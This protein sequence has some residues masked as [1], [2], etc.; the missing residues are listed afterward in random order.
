M[1]CVRSHSKRLLQSRANTHR[2]NRTTSLTATAFLSILGAS[3]RALLWS[4]TAGFPSGITPRSLEPSPKSDNHPTWVCI[5][6]RN[7]LT[8]TTD[9]IGLSY[10]QLLSGCHSS[11]SLGTDWVSVSFRDQSAWY[12]VKTELRAYRR[13]DEYRL[14]FIGNVVVALQPFAPHF[15]QS[16]F[17][18]TWSISES[19]DTRQS[20]ASVIGSVARRWPH[21]PQMRRTSNCP[22]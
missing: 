22:K 2:R 16:S 9:L 3:A 8:P 21:L 1:F 5:D 18:K 14:G 15:E 19:I 12:A 17:G 4:P 6:S 11:D 10:S 20:F 13:S 7:R